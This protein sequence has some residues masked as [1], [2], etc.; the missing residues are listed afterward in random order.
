MTSLFCSCMLANLTIIF[1]E[2]CYSSTRAITL[3]IEKLPNKTCYHEQGKLS[4]KIVKENCHRKLAVELL[5]NTLWQMKK[6]R[7][8]IGP[9][10]WGLSEF[11]PDKMRNDRYGNGTKEIEVHFICI[12]RSTYPNCPCSR[13]SNKMHVHSLQMQNLCLI[14]EWHIWIDAS[15]SVQTEFLMNKD[16]QVCDRWCLHSKDN[17]Y[18]TIGHFFKEL[19]IK[20]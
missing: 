6:D 2:T 1:K 19:Q 15:I 11:H 8:Q 17:V 10:A 4:K 12:L 18:K 16:G 3:V 20:Y 7:E 13:K 14:P 5:L 9:L